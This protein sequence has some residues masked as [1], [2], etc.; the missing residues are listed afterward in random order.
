VAFA[1]DPV[2]QQPETEGAQS[3]ASQGGAEY[4][5]KRRQ[6]DVQIGSDARRY[7]PDRLQVHAVEQRHEC[8]QHDD[9]NLQRAEW[10]RVDQLGNVECPSRHI[11]SPDDLQG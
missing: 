7:K 11:Q 4:V 9:A 6:R 2:R 1:S 10:A 5:A 3:E 8:A